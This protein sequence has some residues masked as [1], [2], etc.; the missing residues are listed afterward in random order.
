MT[1]RGWRARARYVLAVV[2]AQIFLEACGD[3]PPPARQP[4]ARPSTAQST[5]D[6]SVLVGQFGIGPD[7]ARFLSHVVQQYVDAIGGPERYGTVLARIGAQP[8]A[9]SVQLYGALLLLHGAARLG[10]PVVD[11]LAALRSRMFALYYPTQ[12]EFL[13]GAQGPAAGWRSLASMDSTDLSALFQLYTRTTLAE[14]NEVPPPPTFDRQRLVAAWRTFLGELPISERDRFTRFLDAPVNSLEDECWFQYH[15]WRL[16]PVLPEEDSRVILW[17]I[18]TN[19]FA[20]D[21]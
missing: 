18:A 3:A 14:M 4:A 20:R 10:R 6:S 8:T 13:V 15:L 16:L 2:G 17:Q 9:T 7:R 11:S 19:Q 21:R 1:F 12:C 5:I